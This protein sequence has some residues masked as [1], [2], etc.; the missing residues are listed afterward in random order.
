MYTRAKLKGE[1]S[2][3]WGRYM[4]G[5]AF[6]IRPVIRM[7]RGATEAIAKAR[8][9]D[10]GIRRLL[11]HAEACIRA[12]CLMT[13]TIAAAYAGDIDDV[14]A[15][16]AWQSLADAAAAH[17]VELMLAPMSLTVALNVGAGAFGLS[18]LSETPPP[19]A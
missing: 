4:L 3:T 18:Y 7:H 13:P 1:H 14:T 12:G 5:S 10:E 16:P 19:F 2:I 8:G 17:D 11:G 15:W 9:T 6:N